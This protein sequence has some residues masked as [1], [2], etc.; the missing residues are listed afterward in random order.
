MSL[1]RLDS[2][3]VLSNMADMGR[4]RMMGVTI[5]RFLTQLG[6]HDPAAWQEVPGE[7]RER[8]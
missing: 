3:H 8:Y 6:R 4:T 5:K 1:Q 2:T 7:T